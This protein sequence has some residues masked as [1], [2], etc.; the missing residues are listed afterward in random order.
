MLI[1]VKAIQP[2]KKRGGNPEQRRKKMKPTSFNFQIKGQHESHKGSAVIL[3]THLDVREAAEQAF[4]ADGDERPVT[5]RE[6][7][8]YAGPD[9]ADYYGKYEIYES[10]TDS[11]SDNYYYFAVM[12][13]STER[14][15]PTHHVINT[16]TGK[17]VFEGD[18][19]ACRG[20]LDNLGAL[21][22]KRVDEPIG[23]LI[24]NA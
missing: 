17:V 21:G 24:T 13:S 5:V 3:D 18:Y 7:G 15:T 6:I 9:Q 14:I 20:K 10:Y 11:G 12:V 2:N 8:F 23:E 1:F 4:R 19:S 16:T 22:M